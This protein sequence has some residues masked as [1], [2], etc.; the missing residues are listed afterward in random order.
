MKLEELKNKKILIAGYGKEGKAVEEFLKKVFPNIIYDIADDKTHPENFKK[1]SEFDLAIRS[2]GVHPAKLAIPHT[3]STNLF[4]ANINS[5]LTIGITGS[6]G[7]STTSSLIYHLLKSAGKDVR[8]AGN[9]GHPLVSEL[10]LKHQ[11][12]MIYIC[13]LSSFQLIDIQYSP[14]IAVAV[15]IFREHLDYHGSFEVYME[16]KQRI[17]K[18]SKL[19]DYYIYNPRFQ[20]LSTW[21]RLTK[22]KA[23]P[24][25]VDF[26]P[27]IGALPG[28]HNQDNI[29]AAITVAHLFS[30]SN[31]EITTALK[32]FQPLPHRLQ[33]IGTFYGIT[34]YDD[35]ISTTP[36]S[37]IAALETLENVR[38]IFLGGTDR[39]YDFKKLAR[40]LQSKNVENIVLF[41]ESGAKIALELEEIM[42]YNPNILK[43][44]DMGQAVEF[45]Y[46]HTPK[47]AICLLST[48]SPSYSLWKNFEEKGGMFQ[49]YVRHYVH[50]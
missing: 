8:L 6:K 49:L 27:K 9:I 29:R 37:T 19:N 42:N 47:G 22:A 18:F 13:E 14:H 35:A 5:P 33:N 16:A 44:T 30:I 43:T 7:K 45:A 15:S 12:N 46:N 10:L 25:E 23:I 11:A 39:G 36:E 40:M 38:T 32:N 31:D 2:P 4:F 34:F 28:E 17:I 50:E 24:Y 41:P 48:A 20:I 26:I 21:S 1:Q 3:T